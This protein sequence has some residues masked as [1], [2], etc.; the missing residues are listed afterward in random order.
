[1]MAQDVGPSV[2]EPQHRSRSVTMYMYSV[3]IT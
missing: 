3:Y 1:M 2:K